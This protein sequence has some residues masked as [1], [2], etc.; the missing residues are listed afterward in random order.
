LL[1]SKL[2]KPNAYELAE[3]IFMPFPATYQEKYAKAHEEIGEDLDP[4]CAAFTLYFAADV[5]NGTIKT[6]SDKKEKKRP[7]DSTGGHSHK[8]GRCP[9]KYSS[10]RGRQGDC[11]NDLMAT[12]A[13]IT[14]TTALIVTVMTVEAGEASITLRRM[15]TTALV[16]IKAK[17]SPTRALTTTPITWIMALVTLAQIRDQAALLVIAPLPLASL[18]FV[19]RRRPT[20]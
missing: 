20:L 15:A 16:A 1:H 14:T 13:A 10:G 11:R 2:P 18:P 8:R 17:A 7:A 3:A 12:N 4:I 9:D 6:L 19:K 5:K